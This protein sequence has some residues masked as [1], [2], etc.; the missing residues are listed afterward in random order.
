MWE[1]EL[2]TSWPTLVGL[3][4]V[5]YNYAKTLFTL[6]VSS[7]NLSLASFVVSVLLTLRSSKDTYS[8]S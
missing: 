7:V 6:L 5:V 8:F 1:N 3:Q 2:D 4:A